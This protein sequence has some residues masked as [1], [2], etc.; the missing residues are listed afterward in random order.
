MTRTPRPLQWVQL[1]CSQNSK[2]SNKDGRRHT[3]NSDASRRLP[4]QWHILALFQVIEL[5]KG[6]GGRPGEG[7]RAAHRWWREPGICGSGRW[8]VGREFAVTRASAARR[9]AAARA[10][11]CCGSCRRRPPRACAAGCC[12]GPAAPGSSCRPDRASSDRS[13]GAAPHGM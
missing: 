8:C 10:E 7:G 1:P 3:T 12:A 11:R 2:G 5:Q 9:R 4:S 6:G 13:C